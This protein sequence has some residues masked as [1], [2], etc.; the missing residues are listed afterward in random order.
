MGRLAR[1]TTVAAVLFLAVL[2]MLI[3]AS[4][5]VPASSIAAAPGIDIVDLVEQVSVAEI[6]AHVEKLAAEPRD[7]PDARAKA[8]DYI[9]DQFE[10]WGYA[11]Q[12]QTVRDSQNVIATVPLVAEVGGAR[13]IAHSVD[14]VFDVLREK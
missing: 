2:V 9:A 14:R 11:V 6:R 7:D 12:L 8:A 1:G 5:S 4:R 13:P 3:A 10:S